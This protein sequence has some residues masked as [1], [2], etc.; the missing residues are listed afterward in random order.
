MSASGSAAGA[1]HFATQVRHF[2]RSYN[3]CVPRVNINAR[4]KLDSPLGAPN[5]WGPSGFRL[6]LIVMAVGTILAVAFVWLLIAYS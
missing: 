2:A 4:R 5:E 1:S 6:F 3:Q